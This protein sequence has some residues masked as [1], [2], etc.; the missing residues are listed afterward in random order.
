MASF[1][2]TDLQYKNL[3]SGFSEGLLFF[4]NLL[5]ETEIFEIRK[6]NEEWH[7]KE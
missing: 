1:N 4:F 2:F 7:G 6:C 3:D 5:Q